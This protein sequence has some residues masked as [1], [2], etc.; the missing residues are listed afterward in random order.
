MHK[1]KRFMQSS[2]KISLINCFARFTKKYFV[3][4]TKL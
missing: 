1:I 3:K 4:Y 2:I